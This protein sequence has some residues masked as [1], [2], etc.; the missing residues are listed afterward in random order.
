[1]KTYSHCIIS[2]GGSGIGR[3][4][5]E[6]LLGRGCAVSILDLAVPEDARAALDKAAAQGGSRWQSFAVNICE[7]D[8]VAEAASLA[9]AEFG[10]IELAINSAGIAI[11]KTF[12]NMTAAEF[13]HVIDINLKGSCHFAAAVLPYMRRGSRLALIASMAGLVS[14]YAYAAYGASKF[15]VVGLATTLRYEYE[16]LGIGVSC[17]CPPEIKTPLV[18]AERLDS[19]P[20][21]LA[22]KQVG[23]S[24]TLAEAIPPMMK[25]LDSGKWMIIPGV[26]AKLTVL[27]ARHTPGLFYRYL[28]R[29]ICKLMRE[30][31]VSFEHSDA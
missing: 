21:S 24:L 1:M 23:G 26:R 11:N 9:V 15:G 20:V 16:P 3:A 28:H 17:I 27:L 8:A 5:A 30:H 12:A 13:S 19:S 31:R 4:F 10:N 14:N 22:I 6:L 7:A 18:D 2:G 25:G 29:L